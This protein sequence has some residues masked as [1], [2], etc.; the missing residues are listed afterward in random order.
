M[1]LPKVS[2]L[3]LNYNGLRWLPK[4][5]SSVAATDYPNL[6]VYLV[7]NG[8]TDGSVIY[9][10]SSFP[11]VKLIL[12]HE[13]L[14]FAEGYNRAISNISSEYVV[15]L[16]N[17]TEVLNPKWIRY[18]IDKASTDPRMVVVTCEMV[19]LENRSRLDS[20]G[21]MGIPFWRGF[22]G[23]GKEEP[24]KG[25]YDQEGFEPFA[26]CGGA[27]LIKRD[28]FLTLR[29]FDGRFFLYQEDVDLSWRLRLLGYRIGFAHNAQVAHYYSGSS[30]TREIDEWKLY[31]CHRNLLRTILKN[32][33]PSL[34]WALSNY[35]LFTLMI[36]VGFSILEPK[37]AIAAAKALLWNLANFEDTF[38]Q[39]LRIQASRKTSEA[40]VLQKMYPNLR[41]YQPAERPRLRRILDILFEYAQRHRL[42]NLSCI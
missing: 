12:N 4:C 38:V 2:V 13:N 9:V 26:F 41:R 31:Y 33:G 27:A 14:G 34:V 32:C 36:V 23:I 30:K 18:L 8:S 16:N 22:V 25:Q 42:H 28:I 20:V 37:K 10:R 1:Q 40:E 35:L 11:S 19:S 5:L 24:D 21:V 39:R 17:D 7:D 15:L 3:I 29:G 6:D